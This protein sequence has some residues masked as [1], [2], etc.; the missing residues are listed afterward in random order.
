MISFQWKSEPDWICLTEDKNL[1]K[2]D[3][4]IQK[5]ADFSTSMSGKGALWKLGPRI[6]VVSCD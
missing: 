3:A 2:E 4:T 5:E 1:L 6:K